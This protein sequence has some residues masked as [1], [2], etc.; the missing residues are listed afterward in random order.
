MKLG[1]KVQ[2]GLETTTKQGY[3][4]GINL[5][6][7]LLVYVR[8]LFTVGNLLPAH[9]YKYNTNK[10]LVWQWDRG[11][12]YYL[13]GG[14]MS[15]NNWKHCDLFPR[16]K[17]HSIFDVF[18]GVAV[19]WQLAHNIRF[20]NIHTNSTICC[21]LCAACLSTQQLSKEQNTYNIRLLYFIFM[22]LEIKCNKNQGGVLYNWL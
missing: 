6:I 10:W 9:I 12:I 4:Q 21:V 7:N 11:Q 18:L 1:E 20:I 13:N 17:Q 22:S 14:P 8:F 19:T 16:Q 5:N 15:K 2:L 3:L